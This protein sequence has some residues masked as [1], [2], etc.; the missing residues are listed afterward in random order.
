MIDNDQRDIILLRSLEFCICNVAYVARCKMRA[1]A[2]IG[3][4][5][6]ANKI[7]FRKVYKTCTDAILYNRKIL[8][9]IKLRNVLKY[10]ALDHLV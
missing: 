9:N 5:L 4:D 10:V 2:K 8:R 1:F 3:L 7:N 6:S